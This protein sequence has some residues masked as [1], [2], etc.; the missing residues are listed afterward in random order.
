M[1]FF[2]QPGKS[3]SRF[4][5]KVMPDYVSHVNNSVL[6]LRYFKLAKMHNKVLTVNGCCD[7]NY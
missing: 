3:K 7:G 6:H 5:K 1:Q 2:E 4:C